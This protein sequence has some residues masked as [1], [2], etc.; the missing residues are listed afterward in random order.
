MNFKKNVN[1]FFIDHSLIKI[2]VLMLCQIFIHVMIVVLIINTQL[3][4]RFT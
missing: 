4:N 2:E 1:T 3:K